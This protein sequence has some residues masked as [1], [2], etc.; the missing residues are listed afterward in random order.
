MC[1]C[2]LIQIVNPHL[3]IFHTVSTFELPWPDIMPRV[4]F[5][6]HGHLMALL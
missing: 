1:S 6:K 3:V 4:N 2:K 5:H